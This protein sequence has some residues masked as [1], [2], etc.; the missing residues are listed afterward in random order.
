[1]ISVIAIVATLNTILAQMTMAAR[2]IYGIVLRD[3]VICPVSLVKCILRYGDAALRNRANCGFGDRA[4]V[5]YS[6]REIGGEHFISNACDL[7]AG[8]SG[9]VTTSLQTGADA[10]ATY[11][12]SDLGLLRQASQPALLL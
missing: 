3:K 4:S 11:K 8:Q 12:H 1:M 2:A 7:R 9:T 10:R 5:S 6:V